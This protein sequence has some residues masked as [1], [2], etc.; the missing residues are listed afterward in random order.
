M[1]TPL[2]PEL[3]PYFGDGLTVSVS[4]GQGEIGVNSLL[5]SWGTLHST[6]LWE[7][8]DQSFALLVLL[9]IATATLGKAVG[10][11]GM[12]ELSF[13]IDSKKTNRPVML[14]AGSKIQGFFTLIGLLIPKP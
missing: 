7:S 5:L 3:R 4:F 13:L 1:L 14:Q 12:K 6:V 11:K 10:N 9:C 2:I 8:L